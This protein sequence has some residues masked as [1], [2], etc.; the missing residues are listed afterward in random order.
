MVFFFLLFVGLTPQVVFLMFHNGLLPGKEC[1][2]G[3]EERVFLFIFRWLQ[4][5]AEKWVFS[6]SCLSG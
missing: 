4:K 5:A 6:F 1:R 2:V 3:R